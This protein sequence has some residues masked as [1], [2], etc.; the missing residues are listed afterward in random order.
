MSKRARERRSSSE[1]EEEG[2]S[3]TPRID[4]ED[5]A[6]T[7]VHT[8]F[9]PFA[10]LRRDAAAAGAAAGGADYGINTAGEAGITVDEIADKRW[11]P[12]D[13]WVR[14]PVTGEL[15][16]GQ[17]GQQPHNPAEQER[18]H[19]FMQRLLAH[20]DYAFLDL[21]VG[22]STRQLSD[23]AAVKDVVHDRV[24]QEELRLAREAQSK[25]L[26]QTLPQRLEARKAVEA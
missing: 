9:T 23:F 18:T 13:G 24:L 12:I 25:R 19:V 4:D 1:E 10:R 21:C 17:R 20:P 14:D 8:R 26:A 6:A 7:R 2:R 22:R 3:V 16:P 11:R 15:Y 5:D